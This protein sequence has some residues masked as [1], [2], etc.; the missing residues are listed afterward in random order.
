MPETFPT[1]GVCPHW[2]IMPHRPWRLT[3]FVDGISTE[4]YIR[5]PSTGS[6]YTFHTAHAALAWWSR[7][8]QWYTNKMWRAWAGARHSTGD[9]Q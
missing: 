9:T 3:L 1:I 2:T 6:A 5:D 4:D 7:K 8:G